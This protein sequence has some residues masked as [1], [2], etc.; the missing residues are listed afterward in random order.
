MLNIIKQLRQQT[1]AGITNCKKALDEAKGDMDKAIEI[2]RKKGQKVAAA[3][4][5]REIK[6]GLI[7]AYIHTEGK[8]GVMIE[9]GCET[10]FVARNKEFKILAHDLAMQV[11]A[12]DPLYLGPEDIP[13]EIIKKEKE[14]I[15]EGAK[16]ELSKKPKNIIDKIIQGKLEKYYQEVCLLKQPFIKNDKITVEELI[17]EKIAKLEENIRVRQFVRYSL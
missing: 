9:L 12:T 4:Q 17:A 5:A 8:I 11:A 6:Q 2:L 1:G 15:Q 3:K 14:M 10:D 16:E 7:E 13:A